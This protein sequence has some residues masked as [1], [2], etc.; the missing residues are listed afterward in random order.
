MI[1]SSSVEDADV[2]APCA[3]IQDLLAENEDLLSRGAGNRKVRLEMLSAESTEKKKNGALGA[4]IK[5][6]TSEM[7]RSTYSA[8]NVLLIGRLRRT[9]WLLG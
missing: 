4:D 3:H 7:S 6:L 1:S 2:L 8:E 5:R 9:L